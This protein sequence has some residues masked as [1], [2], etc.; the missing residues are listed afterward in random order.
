MGD[1]V[2][3]DIKEVEFHGV[4]WTEMLHVGLTK[5][6]HEFRDGFSGCLEVLQKRDFG[7]YQE[8]GHY[9]EQLQYSKYHLNASHAFSEDFYHHLLFRLIRVT[10]VRSV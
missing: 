7:V 5:A 4:N 8:N 9:L 2:A 3:T 10:A 1:S 6:L